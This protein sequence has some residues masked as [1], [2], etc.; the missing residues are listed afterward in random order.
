MSSYAYSLLRRNSLLLQYK[1]ITIKLIT[2]KGRFLVRLGKDLH[3]VDLE[4][5]ENFGKI[6]GDECMYEAQLHVESLVNLQDF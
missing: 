3:C 5:G 1:W 6:Y 4:T 2:I